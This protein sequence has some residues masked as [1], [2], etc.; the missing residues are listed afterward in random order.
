MCDNSL[1]FMTLS[2]CQK[3]VKH[4]L[5]PPIMHPCLYYKL[6]KRPIQKYLVL[7][8]G[9]CQTPIQAFF[10]SKLNELATILPRIT[11]HAIKMGFKYLL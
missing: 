9:V 5:Q 10:L 11:I 4:F 2:N 8:L 3:T 7:K 1:L 6:G